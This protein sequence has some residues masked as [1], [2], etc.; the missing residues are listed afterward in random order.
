MDKDWQHRVSTLEQEL[1]ETKEFYLR[2]IEALE[3]GNN[4]FTDSSI[5]V[6]GESV[7]DREHTGV[8]KT[9]D[10]C[11]LGSFFC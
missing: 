3:K 2:R 8:T 10:E 4:V 7:V 9:Q 5:L 11:L 6:A 1:R